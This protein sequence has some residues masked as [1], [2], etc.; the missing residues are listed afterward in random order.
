MLDWLIDR[1]RERSTWFGVV[2]LMTAIGISL[3]PAQIDAI[4]A[5]GMAVAGLVAVITRG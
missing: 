4:A 5:A 3:S 2:S 1:M